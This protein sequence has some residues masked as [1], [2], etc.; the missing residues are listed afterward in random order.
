MR[1]YSFDLRTVRSLDA[2]WDLYTRVV[3]GPGWKD[4]GRNRDAYRDALAGGPGCP[5]LPCRFVFENAPVERGEL[6]ELTVR[7]L[8][9][10]QDEGHPSARPLLDAQIELLGYGIGETLLH[11]ILDPA[12]E[13][14]GIEVVVRCD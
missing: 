6:I 1:D 10:G 9:R 8:R 12:L 11:W 14:A 13:A 7:E 3:R 2:W 4:F 5:E